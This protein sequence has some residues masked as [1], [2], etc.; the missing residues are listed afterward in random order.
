VS[1]LERVFGGRRSAATVVTVSLLLAATV[2]LAAAIALLLANAGQLLELLR[3]AFER[4]SLPAALTLTTPTLE[5]LIEL[6]REYTPSGF[7]VLWDTLRGSTRALVS[8]IVFLGAFHSITL[9]WKHLALLFAR[10]SPISADALGRLNQAFYETG[11]GL[12]AGIGLTALAQ[13]VVATVIYLALGVPRAAVFGLFTAVAAVVPSIGTGL[14]WGPIALGLA[15]TG[16]PTRAIILAA[17][18]V[19]VISFVDNALRPALARFGKLNLPVFV[20]FLAMLGGIFTL[21]PSGVVLGPLL[22]RLTV[23]AVELWRTQS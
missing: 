6:A 2:P 7:R 20:L 9:H 18:G 22:V 5:Q 1:A 3:A 11:R 12:L 15:A 23:E 8:V 16:H 10:L 17:S 14:V 19:G 4:G 13:G 21:G